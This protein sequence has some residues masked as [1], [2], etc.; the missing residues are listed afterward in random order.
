SRNDVQAAI[1]QAADHTAP[2]RTVGPCPVDHDHADVCYRF[3]HVTP[4]RAG[5]RDSSASPYTLVSAAELYFAIARECMRSFVLVC[6][7]RSL[8]HL[9]L[10]MQ[11]FEP[12]AGID[13]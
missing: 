6:R 4:L 3:A 9:G 7:C 10:E 13:L 8:R 1:F 5:H 11:E 12:L 2:A